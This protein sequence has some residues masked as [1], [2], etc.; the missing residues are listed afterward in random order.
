[1]P[2]V[3]RELIAKEI[4]DFVKEVQLRDAQATTALGYDKV[5]AM[6]QTKQHAQAFANDPYLVKALNAMFD[7]SPDGRHQVGLKMLLCLQAVDSYKQSPKFAGFEGHAGRIALHNVIN[8]V[9]NQDLDVFREQGEERRRQREEA[10]TFAKLY[11]EEL[12]QLADLPPLDEEAEEPPVEDDTPH[13]EAEVIAHTDSEQ[14]FEQP[15]TDEP[16]LTASALLLPMTLV[17]LPEGD[18]RLKLAF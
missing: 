4:L 18:A 17:L 13:P 12:A 6:M 2:A 7:L 8:S 1:L 3:P 10:K 11:Q 14:H 15:A 9:F 16:L 5:V